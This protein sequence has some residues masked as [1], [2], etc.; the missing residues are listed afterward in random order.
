MPTYCFECSECKHEW[1][2]ILSI[3]APNPE[4]CPVCEKATV[5]KLIA[6][7]TSFILAGSGWASSGYSSSK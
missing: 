1:E 5:K 4:K 2:E 6:G 3:T 7:G